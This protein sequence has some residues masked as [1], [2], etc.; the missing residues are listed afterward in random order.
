MCDEKWRAAIEAQERIAEVFVIFLSESFTTFRNRTFVGQAA[1][2][3]G[4]TY[5]YKRLEIQVKFKFFEAVRSFIMTIAIRL[6]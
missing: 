1:L 4:K 5:N 6:T 2:T 3:S